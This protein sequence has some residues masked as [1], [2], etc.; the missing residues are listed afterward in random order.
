VKNGTVPWLVLRSGGFLHRAAGADEGVPRWLARSYLPGYWI[1][2]ASHI[3]I[4]GLPR[5]AKGWAVVLGW[6]V[7]LVFLARLAYRRDTQRL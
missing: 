5:S 6:T 4:H 2:Q 1:V 3:A 7:V